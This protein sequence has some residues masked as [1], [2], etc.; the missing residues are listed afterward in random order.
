MDKLKEKIA[1]V[2]DCGLYVSFAVRLSKDFKKVYYFS[3]WNSGGFAIK[4]RSQPGE[5]YDEIERINWMFK[6]S[7]KPGEYSFDKIDI[8]IF[9]FIY[10]SDLQDHLVHLGKRVWGARYGDEIELNRWSS[11]AILRD[12][13]LAV[14]PATK[15]KGTERL[16]EHLKSHKNKFIKISHWRGLIDTFHHDNYKLSE[17]ILDYIDN[18]LGAYKTEMDFIIEDPIQCDVESGIDTYII[19]G[20]IP[21]K[22]MIGVE[23]KDAGFVGKVFD[24]EKLPKVLKMSTTNLA[25]YFKK[26]NFRGFYSDE[27]RIKGNTPY[28]IDF[29][30]RIPLPPGEL[31]DCMI[32]NLSEIIWY[33]AEGILVQ[34]KW[35]YKW[36]AVVIIHSEWAEKHDQPIY[37][38]EEIKEYVKLRNSSKIKGTYYVIPQE[39]ELKEIG[40]VV[41]VGNTQEE[42]IEMC[43]T[44]CEQVKGYG[45]VLKSDALDVSSEELEKVEQLGIKF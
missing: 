24:Y 17:P 12:A 31:Y 22:V 14:G 21:D 5:G 29:T 27:Q 25:K 40:G 42:A 3:P 6:Y 13:H 38:P 28:P 8:F 2:V 36:G 35:K 1:L 20:Q 26:N 11:K 16:R 39:A 19:D 34:P 10:F 33:G 44:N 45:L 30:P 7:D 37:F 23:T 9:P 18:E 4:E 41:G 15:V 43:K 32:E